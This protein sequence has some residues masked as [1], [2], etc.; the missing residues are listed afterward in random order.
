MRGSRKTDSKL[1][2][3]ISE[4][5]NEAFESETFQSIKEGPKVK[6]ST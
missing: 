4:Y 5:E 3:N 6:M 1:H 2:M